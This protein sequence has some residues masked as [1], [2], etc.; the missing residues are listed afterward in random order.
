MGR[1]RQIEVLTLAQR[2]AAEL[3]SGRVDDVDLSDEQV[4]RVA[5]MLRPEAPAVEPRRAP[6]V[7][8]VRRRTGGN[9]LRVSPVVL[10]AAT[11]SWWWAEVTRVQLALIS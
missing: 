2:I 3:E 6:H 4:R 7:T 9:L 11:G 8:P 1:S 10:L 5:A